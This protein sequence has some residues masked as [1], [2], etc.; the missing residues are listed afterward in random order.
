MLNMNRNNIIRSIL[1]IVI[2]LSPLIAQSQS[3]DADV[4]ALHREIDKLSEMVTK[5]KAEQARSYSIE[6][7]I[8]SPSAGFNKRDSLRLVRLKKKQAESRVR[9][10]Q[11]TLDIIKI[12]KRLEDPGKRYALAKRMQQPKVVQK[13]P[14]PKG[15]PDSTEVPQVVT[16]R[17]I[18]LASVKLVRK[19]K[20]LDQARLLTIDAL[21]N[22][23]VLKFYQNLDKNARYE[24]YDIADEIVRSDK[25]EL[26]DARRSAIYFFLFTK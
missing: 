3:K 9:I 22:G 12:S 10:D 21:S 6:A 23:Q 4:R 26:V 14:R 1:L 18:D 11:I 25:I 16:A 2:M 20:S 13:V 24:L 8:K 17:S 5:L 7:E 15:E 19:G